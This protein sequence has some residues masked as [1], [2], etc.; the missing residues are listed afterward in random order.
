LRPA[1]AV[2]MSNATAKTI[3]GSIRSF[4]VD[5]NGISFSPRLQPGVQRILIVIE[6]VSTVYLC[7]RK[8][9][10]IENR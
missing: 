10:L 7:G 6:T 5:L 3:S 1:I 8:R 2:Q 4:E 9:T